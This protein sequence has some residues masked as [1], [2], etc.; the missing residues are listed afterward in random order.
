MPEIQ[1]GDDVENQ[2]HED[3]RKDRD[4]A[5]PREHERAVAGP[6]RRRGNTD[7][8]VESSEKLCE[9]FDHIA[10]SRLLDLII[11]RPVLYRDRDLA[12]YLD[13]KPNI[14]GPVKEGCDPETNDTRHR[15]GECGIH[16]RT[17]AQ[18]RPTVSMPLPRGEGRPD[19]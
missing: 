5:K 13:K 18:L 2:D 4:G 7:N 16:C 3:D 11:R 12:R 19:G 17:A 15:H 10:A 1:K 9:R 8:V 14:S 6:G